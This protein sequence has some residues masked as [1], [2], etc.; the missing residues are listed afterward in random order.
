MSLGIINYVTTFCIM[1]NNGN[2]GYLCRWKDKR[3]AS[4]SGK[5]SHG[6]GGREKD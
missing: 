1:T 6:D 5:A 3:V 4:E 2:R